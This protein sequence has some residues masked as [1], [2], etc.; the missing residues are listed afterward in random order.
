MQLTEN[1]I[2]PKNLDEGQKIADLT[3]VGRLLIHRKDFVKT[4]CPACDSDEYKWK[5]SKYG[6]EF[7]ECADCRTFFTNPRPT[8]GVLEEFYRNS[9]NYAFWNKHMFPASEQ[10][11][12]KKIFVPRVD[13]VLQFCRHF[14][15]I[16]ES[17]L[18]VGAGYGT[19]CE[20]MLSRNVFKRVVGVEPTPDLAATCRKKGIETIE[21]PIEKVK[22]SDD[23]LFDVVVNFEVIEHLF[24]P[25][26]FILQCKKSL[27][28]KGLFI[29]TCPNGEG[30][31][32]KVLGS[33]CNSVDH[34]HLNYFNPESL[35]LLFENCGFTVLE[36][37][38]PGKLDAE[39]VRNKILQGEFDI[40]SQP[41]L[42]QVLIEKWEQLGQQFQDFL[43]RAGLS[44]SMWIV[45]QKN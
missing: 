24:S 25:K 13:S 10:A 40:S 33:Q 17:I 1:D 15:V 11:R 7:T 27:K 3:D 41:F 31:D 5:F 39:L 29:L 22:F 12:R 38:T 44:S 36:S 4:N 43:S 37:I 45:A 16:P 21:S 35:K 19:F 18:E 6:L 32:F 42:K 26:D 30:F 20:E 28:P 23:E 34:E 9:V 14:D 8:P 2:R